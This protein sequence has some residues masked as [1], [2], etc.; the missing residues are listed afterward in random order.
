MR[1]DLCQVC[2]TELLVDGG[3]H[4]QERHRLELPRRTFTHLPELPQQLYKHP[5]H[6]ARSAQDH[7]RRL[8]VQPKVHLA[9]ARDRLYGNRVQLLY[10]LRMREA[11]LEHRLPV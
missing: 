4:L 10:D 11:V 9:L 6:L 7:L 3:K 5:Q 2:F 8:A 1:L